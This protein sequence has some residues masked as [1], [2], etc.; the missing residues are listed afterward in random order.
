M[1]LMSCSATT[2]TN[3]PP[4][5]RSSQTGGCT[6]GD[7]ATRDEVGQFYIVDR[8]KDMIVTS[9]FKVY[10][11]EIERVVAAHPAVAMVAVGPVP[12]ELRGELARAYIVLRPGATASEAEIVE[13]C[14]PHLAQFKLPRSVRFVLDLPKTS[15]GK[16]MRRELRKLTE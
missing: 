14:R 11:A 10:P 9:G 13:H 5:R 1:V 7:I 8:L 3:W 2:A 4:V 6:Q 15:T 16:V 12:D